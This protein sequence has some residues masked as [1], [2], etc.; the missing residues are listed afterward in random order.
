MQEDAYFSITVHCFIKHTMNVDSS[1]FTTAVHSLRLVL[2]CGRLQV[3]RWSVA[4]LFLIFIVLNWNDRAEHFTECVF[5]FL[6]G[7][8]PS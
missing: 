3:K 5:H 2:Y 4:K 8:P 6:P 1:I 7:I